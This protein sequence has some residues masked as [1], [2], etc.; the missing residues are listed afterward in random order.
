MLAILSSFVLRKNLAHIFGSTLLIASLVST[1][2]AGGQHSTSAHKRREGLISVQLKSDATAE[3][4]QAFNNLAKKL[5]MRVLKK[6]SA[7]KTVRMKIDDT[8]WNGNEEDVVDLLQETGAVNFAQPDFLVKPTLVPNDTNYSSQ[9]YL[10]TINAPL[11][12][13]YTTGAKVASTKIAD[14]DTGF[15]TTHPD[16]VGNLG[17]VC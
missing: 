5:N 6:L 16:L 3:E 11:A 9:W 4:I 14:C 13:N 17:A 15:D 8:K 1:A 2:N 12:W 10:Q 7:G